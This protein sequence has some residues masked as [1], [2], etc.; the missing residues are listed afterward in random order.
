MLA[1]GGEMRP[2]AAPSVTPEQFARYKRLPR[3]LEEEVIAERKQMAA[4][5]QC[6]LVALERSYKIAKHQRPL[7]QM[8][9]VQ[10]KQYKS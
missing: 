3:N 1:W 8:L 4:A 5:V 7:L 9:P 6:N 10:M 2:E